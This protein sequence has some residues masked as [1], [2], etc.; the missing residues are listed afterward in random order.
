MCSPRQR[1]ASATASFK[2]ACCKWPAH[3]K[4]DSNCLAPSTH[5]SQPSWF[6]DMTPCKAVK[7]RRCFGGTCSLH[8]QGRKKTETCSK[9]ALSRVCFSATLQM[10]VLCSSETWGDLQWAARLI[11]EDRAFTPTVKITWVLR[12]EIMSWGSDNI[13]RDIRELTHSSHQTSRIDVPNVCDWH[14]KLC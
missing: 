12:N 10:N 2:A 9:H 14:A 3:V 6:L 13:W 11:P 5:T 8:L 7:S 4:A 1:S